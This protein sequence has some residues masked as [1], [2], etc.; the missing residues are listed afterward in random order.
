MSKIKDEALKK[1]FTYGII[2]T[3]VTKDISINMLINLVNL[4]ISYN[5]MED[6]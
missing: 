5:C 3:L 1:K 2:K 6:E 4:L